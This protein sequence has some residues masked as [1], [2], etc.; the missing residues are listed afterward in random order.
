MV[1]QRDTTV[2]AARLPNELRQWVEEQAAKDGVTI[3]RWL[4]CLIRQAQEQERD[5]I[6][7]QAEV[8]AE[9]KARLEAERRWMA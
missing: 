1:K 4:L 3:N 8:I 6:A 7:T 5:D 2:T 9:N